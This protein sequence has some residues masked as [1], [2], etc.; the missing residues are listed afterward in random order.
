MSVLVLRDEHDASAQSPTTSLEALTG[1][2]TNLQHFELYS[3]C[4]I[5]SLAPIS[6]LTRL[7]H[8][9]LSYC[10]AA[11][12]E[13]L[14]SLSALHGLDLR[15]NPRDSLPS[16]TPLCSLTDNLQQLSISRGHYFHS[17][18]F[19]RDLTR[20]TSLS[21]LIPIRSLQMAAAVSQLSC[22]LKRLRLGVRWMSQPQEA[23]TTIDL[24]PLSTL[25]QL[26]AY[27]LPGRQLQPPQ[28]PAPC[29]P[30][31]HAAG[32]L[33]VPGVTETANLTGSPAQ[34][35]MNGALLVLHSCLI[36]FFPTCHSC[37]CLISHPWPMC[38]RS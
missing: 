1:L 12:L 18:T 14:A 30:G 36:L 6:C 20:L 8:L 13:P 17:F 27:L 9:V 24:Q 2:A 31:Q 26:Q 16:C 37:R 29:H 5:T 25:T 28:P 38:R 23:D 10:Q 19:L 7:T 22:S 21:L 4:S 11:S 15:C 32:K 35:H 34:S 33:P 3:A